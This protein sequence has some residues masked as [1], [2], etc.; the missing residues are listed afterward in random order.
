M[1]HNNFYSGVEVSLDTQNDLLDLTAQRLGNIPAKHVF[2]FE[3]VGNNGEY[4]IS[5]VF[6]AFFQ[7]HYC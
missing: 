2:G 7:V 4:G 3:E 6:T 5:V 1:S